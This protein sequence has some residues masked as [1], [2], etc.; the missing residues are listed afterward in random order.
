MAV[1]SMVTLGVGN[2]HG[3]N[4]ENSSDNQLMGVKFKKLNTKC[5]T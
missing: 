3:M 5:E 4:F 1:H 2:L